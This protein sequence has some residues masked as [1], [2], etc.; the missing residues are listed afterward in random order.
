MRDRLCIFINA[1]YCLSGLD[2]CLG[3]DTMFLVIGKLDCATALSLLNRKA[4]GVGNLVGIHDYSAI[5]ISGSTTNSLRK[6]TVTTQ[7]TLFVGIKYCYKR[8]FRKIETLSKQVDTDE[9]I[10]CTGAQIIKNT[11]TVEISTSL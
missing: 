3:S 5:K 10:I 9:N 4:H 8:H 2:Y 7:K 11:N 1:N 6:R